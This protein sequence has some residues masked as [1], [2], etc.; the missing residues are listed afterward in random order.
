MQ[1]AQQWNTKLT[2]DLCQAINSLKNP[3]EVANFLRDIL[4]VK[5]IQAISQRWQVARLLHQGKSFK[6]IEE[7]SGASSATIA[8]VNQWLNYGMDG[9]KTVLK[10]MT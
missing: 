3:D 10:R 4:T 1:P 9:Y 7:I 6:Q 2:K 8:R 5:E